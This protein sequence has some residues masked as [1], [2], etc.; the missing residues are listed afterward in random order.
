MYILTFRLLENR[1][2]LFEEGSDIEGLNGHSI[3]NG[4]YLSVI[5]D[6]IGRGAER[7]RLRSEQ[8]ELIIN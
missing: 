8:P 4:R 3:S 5:V 7:S 6:R 1:T 2:R